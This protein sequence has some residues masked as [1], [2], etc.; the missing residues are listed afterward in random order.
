VFVPAMVTVMATGP[1][2]PGAAL[3]VAPGVTVSAQVANGT[4]S[5]QL[6]G[7]IVVPAGSAGDT[8]YAT[9]VAVPFPVLVTVMTRGVPVRLADSATSFTASTSDETLDESAGVAGGGGTTTVAQAADA[10]DPQPSKAAVPPPPS[11]HAATVASE[12]S[13]RKRCEFLNCCRKPGQP[14]TIDIK[15]IG[16]PQPSL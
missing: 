2:S 15:D 5:P 12:K 7:A 9:D 6:A 3:A 8:V 1:V 16:L 14:N 10:L 11:P 13:T 4:R